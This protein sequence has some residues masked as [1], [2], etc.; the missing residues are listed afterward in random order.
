MGAVIGRE[1]ALAT[2]RTVSPLGEEA[3]VDALDEAV[4]VGVLEEEAKIGQVRYRFAHA[5]FRQTLYEEL[6]APRRIQLHQQVARALEQQ[7]IGRLEEHAA[8]LAEH[9]AH[10]SDATD[11]AKAVGYGERAAQRAVAVNAYGEAVRHL[12]RALEVQE[13]LDPHDRAKRCDL[14][15]A[16][17]DALL[18]AGEPQ[19]AA[20]EVAPDALALAET[21]ADHPRAFRAAYLGAIGLWFYG[22]STSSG[23]GSPE[24][25]LFTQQADRYAAPGTL[26]RVRADWILQQA[27]R[28]ESDEQRCQEL[29][30]RSFHLARQ[31]GDVASAARSAGPL[32]SGTFTPPEQHDQ[33]REIMQQVRTLAVEGL[34]SEDLFQFLEGLASVGLTWG[35]RAAAETT[36]ERV[37]ALADRTHEPLF[38]LIRI[39]HDAMRLMFAGRLVEAAEIGE[40]LAK[41]GEELGIA[42]SGKQMGAAVSR[43]V[44]LYLGRPLEALDKIPASQQLWRAGG[45]FAGQRAMCLAH[46]GRTEEA[47]AILDQFRAARDLASP[48]DPSPA[49][50]L[51]YLLDAAVVAEDLDTL[52]AIYPRMAPLSHLLVT[53]AAHVY[54]IGRLCGEAAV[55]LGYPDQAREH[56]QQALEVCTKVRFR[57]EVAL[58]RLGLAELLLGGSATERIEAQAHLDFAIEEFGVMQ[59]QPA[60]ERAL[61]HKGLLHA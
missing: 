58:T 47:K 11:L 32:L 51:R 16:L 50:F 61:R 48:E 6:S 5:Y 18:P 60:L 9:F 45:V 37:T 29:S 17:G 24:F 20:Q 14:L 30:T 13:V 8:E 4:H 33:R 54:C 41:R 26:E 56:Y 25:K 38:Q 7:Y 21:L 3:L 1:F 2:L 55:L 40:E 23:A 27:A 52:T 57:P 12:E 15:L 19:R 44:L 34:P 22:A 59:M 53:E 10:S 42:A 49:I 36:W 43:R 46:A 28:D 39:R 35:D 31:L